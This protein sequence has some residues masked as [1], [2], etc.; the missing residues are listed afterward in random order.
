M[1]PRTWLFRWL[2]VL[3]YMGLITYLSSQTGSGL[4]TFWFMRFDKVLHTLEYGGLGFLL[5]RALGA[6]IDRRPI[7]WLCAAVLG[8]AFGVVDEF[9]QSFVA[10]RQ[11]NDPGDMLADLIGA[12]LGATAFLVLAHLFSPKPAKQRH[13]E[14][15]S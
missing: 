5:Y 14:L 4:P 15:A 2:P 11:G 9:H 12:S 3:G 7:R 8:L 1:I 13:K 6:S 10:G